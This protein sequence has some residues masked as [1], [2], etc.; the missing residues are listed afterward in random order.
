M[1]KLC[2]CLRRRSD[3]TAEEFHDYWLNKHGPLV[4]SVASTLNMKR[5]VQV[6]AID[7]PMNDA[8]REGRGSP[9]PFD[10][11]AEV[12][13]E[14]MEILQS[15]LADPATTGAAQQLLD[16]ERR[17]IDLANSPMWFSEE[18]ELVG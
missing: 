16:D 1:V 9:E 17:F 4:R 10:G 2:F 11:I 18:H 6:H 5:Y 7:T 14:N 13:W 3:L 15:T 8:V 12:W